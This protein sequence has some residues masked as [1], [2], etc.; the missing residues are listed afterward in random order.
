MDHDTLTEPRLALLAA[1]H[2]GDVGLAQGI[3]LDL[4]GDGYPFATILDEVLPPI[5]E[6][7][8]RRW[9]AG[10]YTISEEH[11]AT[12]A[13][14][15]LL[16]G[17][18]G[19]FDQPEDAPRILVCC[20]VGDLHTMPARMAAALLLAEGYRATFLGSAVPADDLA[21]F[22]ADSPPDAVVV[23]CTLASNLL[24]AREVVDAAHRAGVPVIAGG[25]AF[26]TTAA[27]ANA[28]G[29]DAWVPSLSALVDAMADPPR[30]QQPGGTRPEPSVKVEAAR[31]DSVD[32]LAAAL[33]RQLDSR[34]ESS[35][36]RLTDEAQR[37]LDTLAVAARLHD[38]DLL[39]EHADWLAAH[40]SAVGGQVLTAGDVLQDLADAVGGAD[41]D[42]AALIAAATGDD[43]S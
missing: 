41:L 21:E 20:A 11:L 35:T 33:G 12:A 16:A 31:T 19:A 42:V 5:Q 14:E 1:L 10:D 38:P 13:N 37:L 27:R 39:Q 9:Q 25:R 6:E 18:A 3:V 29:A 2:Q 24:G 40:L 23:A 28:I 4:M 8:G 34:P 36:V 43:R 22:V 32:E 30:T 7:T 17:L 26:G 15:M